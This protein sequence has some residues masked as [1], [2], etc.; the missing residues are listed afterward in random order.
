MSYIPN[1]ATGGVGGMFEYANAAVMGIDQVNTYHPFWTSGVVAGTLAVKLQGQLI[2]NALNSKLYL[3]AANGDG[4]NGALRAY[5]EVLLST[6]HRAPLEQYF[7]LQAGKAYN[8]VAKFWPSGEMVT[9]SLVSPG[10][11]VIGEP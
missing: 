4:S 8:L 3:Y 1:P 9:R 2:K 10:L 11:L 7:A 5:R 6:S